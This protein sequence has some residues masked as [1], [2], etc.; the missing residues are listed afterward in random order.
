MYMI[1][2]GPIPKGMVVMHTCD[3]TQCIQPEHL[4]LTTQR[5]NQLDK[6]LK[7]RQAKGTQHGRAKLT[8]EQVLSIRQD[9]VANK[10]LVMLAKEYNISVHTIHAIRNYETW[11]HLP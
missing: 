4:K 1:C 8:P 9:K 2:N 10:T 11:K 5:G 3:V 6:V 7:G